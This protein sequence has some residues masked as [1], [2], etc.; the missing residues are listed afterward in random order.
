M[1]NEYT[2]KGEYAVCLT[3]KGEKFIIDKEDLD[4]F[5]KQ[6]TKFKN[7]YFC[8]REYGREG[9]Q[10]YIHRYVLDYCGDEYID[11][12]NGIPADN[13][14]CNLR[15]VSQSIQNKNQSKKTR[16][17]TLP[18]NSGIDPQEIP[19]FIY[20]CKSMP[21]YFSVEVKHGN[22]ERF[23]KKTSKSTKISLKDK[24]EQAKEIL[25]NLKQEHPEYFKEHF[26]LN[27]QQNEQAEKLLEEY[28]T[29]TTE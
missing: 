13:R 15:I 1:K 11:H 22:G 23:R 4:K 12:I 3:N 8:F 10:H 9:K 26:R 7:G 2:I 21:D 28:K 29:L 6:I 24:L 25:E 20:Y 16:I 27:G 18:E 19:Q 14:K 5:D 17:T